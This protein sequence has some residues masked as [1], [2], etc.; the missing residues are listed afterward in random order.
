MLL[1]EKMGKA[2]MKVS[3]RKH[4]GRREDRERQKPSVRAGPL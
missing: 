1:G 4:V 2:C 3:P